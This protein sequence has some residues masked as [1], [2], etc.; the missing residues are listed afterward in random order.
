M[1]EWYAAALAEDFRDEPHEEV[2]LEMASLIE[3]LRAAA[4]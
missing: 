1:R 3:D 2:M 4:R